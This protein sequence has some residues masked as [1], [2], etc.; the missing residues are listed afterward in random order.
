MTGNFYEDGQKVGGS[1]P[2]FGDEPST[3]AVKL[4]FVLVHGGWWGAWSFERLIPLLMSRG[5]VA[6]ARDLPG[7]G[8]NARFPSSY[9]RRP[10]EQASFESERSPNAQFTR[11]EYVDAILGAIDCVSAFGNGQVVL[12][13]HS[14]SGALISMVAERCPERIAKLVYL[15]AFMPRTGTA[16]VDY[17]HAP[18]NEGQLIPLLFT[19]DP[20]ATGA[21]RIDHHADDLASRETGRR[22]FC[23]DM[24]EGDYH[25]LV[26]LT[27]PDEAAAPMA[28]P[29]RTTVER[30][31]SVERHY[32]MCLQDYAIRPAMQR[33]FVEEADAFVPQR[34]TVVH[35]LDASHGAVVSQPGALA[36]L[37]VGIANGDMLSQP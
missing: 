5:H 4:P 3:Q 8:L 13:G 31:G 29:V 21:L 11:D 17:I 37:L 1:V 26:N 18:E 33:R 22:A 15:S 19:G 27:T 23:G 14:M 9:M 2:P 24:S 25:A 12:V 34:P 16:I 7:H 35:S 20:A 6:L 36:E 30:W 32:I 10:M 28:T